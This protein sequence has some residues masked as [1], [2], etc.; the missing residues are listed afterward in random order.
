MYFSRDLNSHCPCKRNILPAH[1]NSFDQ[2]GAR[3]A[4]NYMKKY[5]KIKAQSNQ[6]IISR[7]QVVWVCIFLF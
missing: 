6:K 2:S 5:T 3:T 1:L 4:R 7:L